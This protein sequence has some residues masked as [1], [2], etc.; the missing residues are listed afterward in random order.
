VVRDDL[1]GHETIPDKQN[2]QCPD[3]R[4]NEAR[5]LAGAIEPDEIADDYREL[6]ASTPMMVVTTKPF[7]VFGPG[8]TSRAM[9]PAT[10]PITM[11]QRRTPI[12]APCQ[13]A[14]A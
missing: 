7:G 6:C 1:R 8:I 5:T 14:A 4:P 10:N 2:D 11:T 3:G 13:S 9:T 12:K